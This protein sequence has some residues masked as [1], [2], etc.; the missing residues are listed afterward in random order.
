MC[1]CVLGTFYHRRQKMQPRLFRVY[2]GEA[3]MRFELSGR[4]ILLIE[5]ESPRE[6]NRLGPSDFISAISVYM[7]AHGMN[8]IK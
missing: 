8:K 1:V 2:T 3:F 5:I 6:S 7:S 4:H